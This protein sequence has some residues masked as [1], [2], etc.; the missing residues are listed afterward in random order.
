MQTLSINVNKLWEKSDEIKRC[1]REGDIGWQAL[2]SCN[3]SSALPLTQAIASD[4]PSAG[5]AALL[6]RAQP[7]KCLSPPKAG[8]DPGFPEKARANKNMRTTSC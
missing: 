4:I 5:A 7:G 3:D 1:A 6:S 8:V 2:I